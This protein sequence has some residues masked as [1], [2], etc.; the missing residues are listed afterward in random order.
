ML[1][2]YHNTIEYNSRELPGFTWNF[3]IPIP[4]I[5]IQYPGMDSQG[6]AEFL[7]QRD[8]I[9]LWAMIRGKIS[10]PNHMHSCTLI[11]AILTRELLV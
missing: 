4:L 2:C 3:K 11:W 9:W 1:E 7:P 6:W 5:K 10:V 8:N